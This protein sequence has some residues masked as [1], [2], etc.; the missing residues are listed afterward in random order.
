MTVLNLKKGEMISLTKTTLQV[1]RLEGSMNGEYIIHINR[2]CSHKD[3][4]AK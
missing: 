2:N 1:L 4:G 3:S